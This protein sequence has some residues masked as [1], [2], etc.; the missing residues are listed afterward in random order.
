[1]NMRDYNDDPEVIRLA[2]KHLADKWGRSYSL[3]AF[4][5]LDAYRHGDSLPDIFADMVD[6]CRGKTTDPVNEIK[7]HGTG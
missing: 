2:A 5:G 4:R 7:S 1:M 6:Y 3:V